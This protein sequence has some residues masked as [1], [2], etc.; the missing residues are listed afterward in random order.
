MTKMT[1]TAAIAAI[2]AASREL[3]LPTVRA[4]AER[5]AEVAERSR[6]GHLAYLAD[7]LSAEIDDRA[8]RRRQ[9]RIREARFPRLKR[10]ADFD[11]SASSGRRGD[12]RHLG[13]GHLP[14]QG[15]ARGPA[16]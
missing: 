10:L 4:E 9:R 7:V 8:E 15:R 2:G 12:H 6:A 13:L 5:L 14:R 1:Q 11:V 3:H 16:R